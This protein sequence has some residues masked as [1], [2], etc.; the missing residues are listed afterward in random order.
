MFLQF[1]VGVGDDGGD[2]DGDV[3]GGDATAADD[4]DVMIT[5]FIVKLD[6]NEFKLIYMSFLLSFQNSIIQVI[7]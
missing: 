6:K 1:L 3:D 4:A 7:K 5:L 2:D